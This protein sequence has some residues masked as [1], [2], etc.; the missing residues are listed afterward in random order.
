M[1]SMRQ[2]GRHLIILR[3][4]VQDIFQSCGDAKSGGAEPEPD[5]F[6][7]EFIVFNKDSGII[8]SAA[9]KNQDNTMGVDIFWRAFDDEEVERMWSEYPLGELI[10]LVEGDKLFRQKDKGFLPEE[11]VYRQEESLQAK[12]L[13]RQLKEV[14]TN[15][16]LDNTIE[17]NVKNGLADHVS[18]ADILDLDHGFIVYFTYADF[19]ARYEAI[20]DATS[21]V[22]KTQ[23][24]N[25]DENSLLEESMTSQW[26]S[27]M[28]GIDV[29][30][31]SDG[32]LQEFRRKHPSLFFKKAYMDEHRQAAKWIHE[33]LQYI[34]KVFDIADEYSLQVYSEVDHGNYEYARG[35]GKYNL[36]ARFQKRFLGVSFPPNWV[37]YLP[38]K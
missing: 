32:F 7:L 21:A 2:S 19:G 20:S 12:I 18:Q 8:V 22:Y 28:R 31:L 23:G 26:L 9:V 25:F 10:S 33:D 1:P 4:Q 30:T 3:C 29:K 35:V 5:A 17:W 6:D 37:K 27:I 36:V 34:I 14:I 16:D 11:T 13:S 24:M 38:P 15:A